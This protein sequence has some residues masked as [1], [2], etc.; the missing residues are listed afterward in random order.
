MVT[1]NPFCTPISDE[2]VAFV[3]LRQLPKDGRGKE[4]YKNATKKNQRFGSRYRA[5]SKI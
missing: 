1:K 2:K 3:T 5:G 4:R